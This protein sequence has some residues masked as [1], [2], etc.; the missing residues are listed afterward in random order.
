[1]VLVTHDPQI[2]SIG[3]RRLNMVDGELS[4]MSL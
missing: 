4:A 3:T 2:G 1:M